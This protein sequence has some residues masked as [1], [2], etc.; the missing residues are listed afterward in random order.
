MVRY[1]RSIEFRGRHADITQITVDEAGG[2]TSVM[3]IRA[4]GP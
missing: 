3:T 4:D 1:L 2:N